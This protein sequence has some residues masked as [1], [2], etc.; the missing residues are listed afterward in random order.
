MQQGQ[1]AS[2]E[3]KGGYLIFVESQQTQ[4]ADQLQ[5]GS[6]QGNGFQRGAVFPV[7]IACGQ[8]L[9]QRGEQTGQGDEN[10]DGPAGKAHFQQIQTYIGGNRRVGHPIGAVD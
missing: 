3:Q 8:G 6:E 7:G 1:T 4:A 10:A 9:E 5:Q 2:V